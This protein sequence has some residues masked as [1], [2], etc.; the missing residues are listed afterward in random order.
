VCL[1]FS[2]SQTFSINLYVF[3][4]VGDVLVV[5]NVQVVAV[6]RLASLMAWRAVYVTQVAS[7]TVFFISFIVYC[8]F[9]F[10]LIF[11]I[12]SL[13]S[14]PVFLFCN[15]CVVCCSDGV[16]VVPLSLHGASALS[17]NKNK[18]PNSCP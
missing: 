12:V 17:V 5:G 3:E 9:M 8:N 10:Q 4:C 18:T 11:N 7:F 13:T 15:V 6:C 1:V 14:L 2:A 16:S